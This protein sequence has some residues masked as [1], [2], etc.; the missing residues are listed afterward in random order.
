MDSK[1]GLVM[2]G[3]ALRGVFTAGV[4]DELMERKVDFNCAVGVSA[5]A[6]FGTNVKSHQVGRCIRFNMNY[7]RDPRYVSVRSFLKTGDFFGGE[8]CFYTLTYDLDPFDME[9]FAADPME[10][11]SVCTDI[12]TGKPV[13]HKCE[14]GDPDGDMPWIRASATMPL[15][16]RTVQIEDGLY[17][18]GG[19]ADSIPLKYIESL[20]Y[21]KNVVIRTKPSSFQMRPAGYLNLIKLKYRKYPAFIQAVKNRHIMYNKTIEYLSEQER[22]EKTFVFQ[23]ESE[24]TSGIAEHNPDKL[25]VSYNHGREVVRKQWDAFVAWK[26]K[27]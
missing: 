22:K 14:K 2:E 5:G 4:T 24:L 23:P 12:K 9:A 27:E 11:Y 25:L 10:F 15:L 16:A 26:N 8:F 21:E 7:C 17:L 3:G 13:Y 1:L 18:D 19:I 6:I 20:G